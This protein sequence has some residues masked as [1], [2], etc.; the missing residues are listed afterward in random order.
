MAADKATVSISASVLPDD[1][2]AAVGGT[3]VHEIADGAG[4]VSKWISYAIDIDTSSEELI[5]AGIGYLH[6][7]SASG[8]SPT[9][10][11]NGDKVEF[12]VIKHSGYRSDG[13]TESAASEC[14]HFNFTDSTAGAA[15]TGN[16]Q[17]NPGEMWWGRMSGTPDNQDFTALSISNDVKV[18]V[19]AILDDA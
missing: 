6:N 13:T 4:D 18:L 1:M 10:V 17:L 12:I 19:Y 2:K 15:A 9:T 5:P 3:S 8:L 11:A 16:I 7:Q 14:I